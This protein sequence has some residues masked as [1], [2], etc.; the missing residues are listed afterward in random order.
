MGRIRELSEGLWSGE[1]DPRS[2]TP[3][4]RCSILEPVAAR[5]AFVSSFANATAF[6]TDDGLVLVDTG[7]FLLAH[8]VHVTVRAF[9]PRPLHTAVFTHGHADHCF[10]VDLYEAEQGTPARVVAHERVPAR[11]ARYRL[12]H[13]YNACINGRQFR[14]P[15]SWPEAFRAPDVTY[16]S[17]L[18]LD[19]GGE[20]FELHH[21]EGETDDATWVWVPSRAVVCV[22]DLFIWACPNAGNP[23]KVQRYPREWAQALRTSPRSRPRCSAPGTGRPSSGGTACGAR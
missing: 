6:D 4:R 18:E 13:G 10:G 15:P 16:T 5:T 21:A 8:Q 20:R 23:Q 22:G 2:T 14:V 17:G 19:V 1:L 3:S 9:T 11:F 7:S 12:T